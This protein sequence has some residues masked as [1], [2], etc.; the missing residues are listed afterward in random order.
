MLYLPTF[1]GPASGKLGNV[2]ASRNRY[3]PYLRAHNPAP[4]DPNTSEQ[5][6]IR[7]AMAYCTAQ[8]QGLSATQ[9][10][11]WR[12]FSRAFPRPNRLGQC[13]PIGGFQEFVRCNVIR[14]FALNSGAT[15]LGLITTPPQSEAGDPPAFTLTWGT[16]GA[17]LLISWSGASPEWA[18][19]TS[20][21]LVIWVSP[22]LD[23]SIHWYRS[24]MTYETTRKRTTAPLLSPQ[25]R[26]LTNPAPGVSGVLFVKTRVTNSDGRLSMERWDRLAF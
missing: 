3:G 12:R 20:A 23:S 24:P 2:V 9:R 25:T 11:A 22:W 16:P 14:R 17:Q 5:Q 8:W 21:G 15:G 10:D 26:T 6:A 4:T 1:V 7:N 13:H 18:T 19:S